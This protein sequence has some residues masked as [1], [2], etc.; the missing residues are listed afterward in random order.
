M[1]SVEQTLFETYGE[2][3]LKELNRFPE[4]EV[5][6]LLNSLPIEEGRRIDFFDRACRFY[7][8]ASA[9]AFALGLHLGLSLLN[10]DVRRQGP[11]KG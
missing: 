10:N 7:Y 8:Q 4:R 3:L 11:Q 9:D 2:S 6:D 1:L 5:I